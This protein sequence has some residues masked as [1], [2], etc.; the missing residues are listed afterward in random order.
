[1][2]VDLT[3]SDLG[4]VCRTGTVRVT[5]LMDIETFATVHQMVSTV[6]G[7]LRPGVNAIDC[8]CSAFPPDP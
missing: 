3:R 1:M 7:R 6:E 5:N 8:L 2:I 4:R